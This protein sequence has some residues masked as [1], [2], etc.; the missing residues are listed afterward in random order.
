MVV[1]PRTVQHQHREY[2]RGV[3]QVQEHAQVVAEGK[4]AEARR[5]ASMAVIRTI[6]A[7]AVHGRSRAAAISEINRLRLSGCTVGHKLLNTKFVEVAEF[8]AAIAVRHYLADLV[9]HPTPSLGIRSDIALFGDGA[10][11]GKVFRSVRSTVLIIGMTV[12]TPHHPTDTVGCILI[13]APPEGQDGRLAALAARIRT[14]IEAP[15]WLLTPRTL[16]SILAVIGTDGAYR[17]FRCDFLDGRPGTQGRVHWDNFHRLDHAGINAMRSSKVCMKF[18]STL[19]DLES[20]FGWGQGFARAHG[21]PHVED[22]IQQGL[23][24]EA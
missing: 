24:A 13:G 18:L 6:I 12:S 7:G 19:H 20:T 2:S 17:G 14:C 1:P 8:C 5:S 10:T 16:K 15:P 22:L 4:Q 21:H 23:N 3:I 11:I 9:L